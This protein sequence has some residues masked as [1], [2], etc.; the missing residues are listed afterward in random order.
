MTQNIASIWVSFREVLF[1]TPFFPIQTQ[2][3]KPVGKIR[4]CSVAVVV[5][6]QIPPDHASISLEKKKKPKVI[7]NPRKRT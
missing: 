6:V 2:K 5:V 1:E 7:S 3:D 4:Q